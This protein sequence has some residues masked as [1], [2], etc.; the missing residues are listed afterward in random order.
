MRVTPREIER[1]GRIP[2]PDDEEPSERRRIGERSAGY[3]RRVGQP[4]AGD[5]PALPPRFDRPRPILGGAIVATTGR[6]AIE[7][8][9]ELLAIGGRDGGRAARV[10]RP[11][12]NATAT[13]D[14]ATAIRHRFEPAFERP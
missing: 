5:R 4:L 2:R 7:E 1:F 3:P 12:A 13:S 8:E 10:M 14:A 6:A 9:R 11:A